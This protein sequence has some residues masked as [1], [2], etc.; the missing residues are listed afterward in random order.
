MDS[1]AVANQAIQYIGGN[2]PPVTGQAPNFDDS[3]AGIALRSLYVPCVATVV[4]QFE[5]PFA[6]NT[7]TLALTGNTCPPPFSVEYVFPAAAVEIWQ[8]IPGTVLDPNNPLP[9]NWSIANNVVNGTQVRVIQ[10]DLVN[11]KAVINN[12]PSES[13]WDV[14]F[15]EAV[16][17]LLASE[18]AMALAGKPD[19]AQAM[20]ET[21]GAFANVAKSRDG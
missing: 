14:E 20:L 18:L 13:A 9:Q 12:N 8:L 4:K 16:V 15:R 21:G 6:R 17:R 11:A 2:E 5:Y 7:V 10:T 19:V 3:T 1:N